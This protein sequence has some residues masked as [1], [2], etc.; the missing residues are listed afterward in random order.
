VVKT[1]SDNKLPPHTM[2]L[3]EE[4]LLEVLRKGRPTWTTRELLASRLKLQ[5]VGIHDITGLADALS[6]DYLN[7]MLKNANQRTFGEETRSA[8]LEEC[9]KRL[10][11]RGF[12]R[13]ES[14]EGNP[15]EKQTEVESAL[16]FAPRPLTSKKPE[17][18]L[19]A[20]IKEAKKQEFIQENEN[21]VPDLDAL[22]KDLN[23]QEAEEKEEAKVRGIPL[24]NLMDLGQL[25]ELLLQI[26]RVETMTAS[27]LKEEYLQRGFAAHEDMPRRELMTN[28][29]DVVLW[30]AY[31]DNVVH[32]V[33]RKHK[34]SVSGDQTRDECMQL[35][36]NKTWEDMGIPVNRLPDVKSAQ[37]VLN[38]CIDL[39]NCSM[40]TLAA[41]A[42]KYNLRTD[43]QDREVLV[44]QLKHICI[45]AH[46]SRDELRRECN[47]RRITIAEDSKD[48]VMIMLRELVAS[49]ANDKF[50]TWNIPK[51]DLDPD[52]AEDVLRQIERLHILGTLS[53]QAECRKQRIPFKP[54]MGNEA[55]IE[56][57]RNVI[58]W[59]HLSVPEFTRVSA[60]TCSFGAVKSMRPSTPGSI[61]RHEAILAMLKRQQQF[62]EWEQEGIPVGRL[63]SLDEAEMVAKEFEAIESM[64]SGELLDWYKQTGFPEERLDRSDLVRL[65]KA[66][67]IWSALPTIE[68]QKE[69][70]EKQISVQGLSDESKASQ[71]HAELVD[72][73]CMN[74]RMIHWDSRGFQAKRI[75]DDDIVRGMVVQYEIFSGLSFEELQ[76]TFKEA[77]LPMAPGMDKES[78]LE[79][80]KSVM[81]WE[82]LPL[83][84]VEEECRENM[85]GSLPSRI[86]SVSGDDQRRSM[87]VRYLLFAMYKPR[88]EKVGVPVDRLGIAQAMD[89]Y[90]EFS[91]F[92]D[93]SN[94][95]LRSS[96]QGMAVPLP[97]ETSREELIEW[98]R[99]MMLWSLLPIPELFGE[100]KARDI[101]TL[102]FSQDID[103]DE[104]RDLLIVRL[105]LQSLHGKRGEELQQMATS[106]RSCSDKAE[107]GSDSGIPTPVE[108]R[109]APWDWKEVWALIENMLDPLIIERVCNVPRKPM[110]RDVYLPAEAVSWEPIEAAFFVLS[111]GVFHPVRAGRVDKRPPA[112]T[113]K[114][115]LLSVTC[116]TTESRQQFHPLLYECFKAQI[117]EPKELVIVDSGTRP[118]RFFESCAERDPRVIYRFFAV[119]DAH[120]DAPRK[121]RNQE[122]SL[123]LKRNIACYLARGVAI[124]HFDDD[125]LYAPEYLSWMWSRLL[126]EV[127]MSDKV[128]TSPDQ[129]VDPLMAIK[130]TDWHLLDISTLKFSYLDV[131]ADKDIPPR[132]RRGWLYGW[133]FS[134]F[135]SRKAW[136]KAPFPDVEFAEDAGFMEALMAQGVPVTLVRLPP[137]ERKSTAPGGP[138]NNS[139]S[140]I[141]GLVAHSQ[142]IHSTS[143]GEVIESGELRGKRVGTS[144]IMPTAFNGLMLAVKSAHKGWS[145]INFAVNK[146]IIPVTVK[147]TFTKGPTSIA[148]PQKPLEKKE[149]LPADFDDEVHDV[150]DAPLEIPPKR[151]RAPPAA[152][153]QKK[154]LPPGQTREKNRAKFQDFMKQ[155]ENPASDPKLKR[156][157]FEHE[158]MGLKPQ[159]PPAPDPVPETTRGD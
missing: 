159:Q 91:A 11:S 35:L 6:K 150:D 85:G 5:K 77:S 22:L 33:C 13:P 4:E 144:V 21:D 56:R 147:P 98:M 24:E 125:D 76:K 138:P 18:V 20:P 96:L 103:E 7:S 100:C 32:E 67:N 40:A 132:D 71:R 39:D 112:A 66:V 137:A 97:P 130:L 55:S 52:S 81:V 153:A 41:K 115:V 46:L 133:G 140:S 116:P 124:A 80:L 78:L 44:S 134:Y 17:E 38:T 3:L 148:P 48:D 26:R 83:T 151:S 14:V 152:P 95:A 142:H 154:G 121:A 114:N 90:A 68:L 110:P 57:L 23:R 43:G 65:A 8:L 25:A 146:G 84:E 50:E 129:G 31:K 107:N 157:V 54:K 9:M 123:G 158:R 34:I 86:D 106:R 131:L 62:S 118:S 101:P 74:D 61:G 75:K 64:P 92:E 15:A 27:K 105:M 111:G 136:E 128:L 122:W 58:I 28:L 30:E 59:K 10:A 145:T 127:K 72:R 156:A 93:D 94:E 113:Q 155:K 108:G 79:A 42:H 37:S 143:G 135:F 87:M 141:A 149:L 49:L 73:L 104:L 70:Q 102:G 2:S 1:V 126:R 19:K 51:N 60:Q 82:N 88:Y 12:A 53:L 89:V 99:K 29:R 16:E 117:H 63:K 36:A 47:W 119:G 69:C 120:V 109:I 139:L 45:W